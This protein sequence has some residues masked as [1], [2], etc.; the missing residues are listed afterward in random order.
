MN[1][2]LYKRSIRAA[3]HPYIRGKVQRR[4]A[5]AAFNGNG[6]GGS[7]PPRNLAARRPGP[8]AVLLLDQ[9]KLDIHVQG[10]DDDSHP[11]CKPWLIVIVDKYTRRVVGSAVTPNQPTPRELRRLL[12]ALYRGNCRGYQGAANTPALIGADS[13]PSNRS[14][15]A[16]DLTNRLSIELHHTPPSMCGNK[17]LAERL[18]SAL[19]RDLLSKLPGYVSRE[20]LATVPEVDSLLTLTEL[21]T[22]IDEWV[23]KHNR[24][25]E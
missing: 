14:R 19:G 24:R 7:R 13:S 2:R 4:S 12:A 15:G 20:R 23:A 10:R 18:F 1:G 21:Q 8:K 17:F 5:Y 3:H 25:E 22:L 16:S 11:C 9:T 6:R